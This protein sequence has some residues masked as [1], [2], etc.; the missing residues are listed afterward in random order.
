M[1]DWSA[2]I[3]LYCVID[4]DRRLLF[5]VVDAVLLLL[6]LP[7]MLSLSNDTDLKQMSDIEGYKDL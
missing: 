7:E 5:F 1:I 2:L 3:S 6:E 4:I